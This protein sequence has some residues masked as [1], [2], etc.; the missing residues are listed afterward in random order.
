LVL[1]I[2]KNIFKVFSSIIMATEG[3]RSVENN[4]ALWSILITVL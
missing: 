4:Y 1:P 3:F 2:Y